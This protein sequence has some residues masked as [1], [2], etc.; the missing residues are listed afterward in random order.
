M[1]I[2]Y[3]KNWILI[4][5]SVPDEPSRIRVAVWRAIKSLGA[6]TI[7]RSV[8]AMPDSESNRK[9]IEELTKKTE[10]GYK[11]FFAQAANEELNGEIIERGRKEREEE[12]GEIIEKCSDFLKDINHEISRK[13]FTYEELEENEADYSKF[14][15]WLQEAEERDWL[16]LPIKREVISRIEE[17]R[18]ILDDFSLEVE[19]HSK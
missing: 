8:Y 5:Y 12:Y 15:R 7:Q 9:K 6:I 3:P 16:D 11:I 13:N 4:T 1:T 17:C 18:K 14:I 19:K 10:A 2:K